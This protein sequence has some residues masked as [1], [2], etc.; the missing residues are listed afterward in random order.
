MKKQTK[1]VAVLST[2]ALL[3]IGASMTSF[4]ATGWAEEDGTWVYY[5]R[6]GERVTDKWAKSGNNWYYLDGNGEMA[7][8]TLIEDGDNYYYVD[9]NGVMAA[10][11]WVAID[12]EDTGED[13]EPEHYWYYFQANGKAYTNGDNSKVSLKTINGKKYAFD[14]EGKMLYGWVEEGNAERLDNSDNDAVIK[15]NPT[16]YFGGEDDGAMTTGWLQIDVTYD[17]ATNNDYKYV[18]AAFNDDEDQ[19]RWFY[20][21]SN[22][23]M[24]KADDGNKTKDKT[25]NGKKYAFDVHGAMV[26]EWSLNEKKLPGNGGLASY[27]SAVTS[28]TSD[29]TS[30]KAGKKT[31]ARYTQAWRYYNSVE[32][33][34]RVSKG[35]F[36]VVSAEYINSGKYDD[37]EDAWYYADGNGKLYAGQF[38]T[39]KGKKYAFYNDGRMISG[40]HF[41]LDNGNDNLTVAADDDAKNFDN[42][43]DFLD[44]AA[45]YYEPLGY[46]CYY[47]GGGED[48]VMRTNKTTV[49]IDGE[50]HNFYFQKS[51][52][53]KGAGV[54]GEKDNKLYQS[55][56]LLA[57][58]SDDKYIPVEKKTHYKADGTEDY[59]TY[60]K[61]S[62]AKKFLGARGVN[63]NDELVDNQGNKKDGKASVNVG[64]NTNKKVEDLSEAYS[65]T[66]KPKEATD[67]VKYEY[68]LVNTS[69]K[70]IDSKTKSKDGNDYYYVTAKT[71]S[72]ENG[73]VAVYVED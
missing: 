2:A 6:N 23:K 32:D 14:D 54:T 56:M 63:Y 13:D 1:L 3:A 30:G 24:V 9:V 57:A 72:G 25:I 66:Y 15:N 43:D 65:I 48:G 16:Y 46:K 33:G 27:S 21:K 10:N 47:F 19:T 61:L 64:N 69:G 52:G 28:T 50:N 71:S 18:A 51:G 11:Q 41:I 59:V 68:I 7:V 29:V 20:F 22:G 73:I 34:S 58:N 45:N 31:D 39:I 70:V 42:E 5:D 26:A 40:L 62:D 55:G 53:H 37:D 17:D 4:A 8:D 36:K 38:K 12:N 35:W 44:N 49:T 60:T 67:G